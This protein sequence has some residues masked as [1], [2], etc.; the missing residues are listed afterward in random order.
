MWAAVALSYYGLSFNS[1]KLSDS[2]HTDFMLSALT[3]VLVRV[4]VRVRVKG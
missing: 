4:R 1:V 3:E 2:P